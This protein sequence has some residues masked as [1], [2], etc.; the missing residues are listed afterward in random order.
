MQYGKKH[1][2]VAPVTDDEWGKL[3]IEAPTSSLPDAPFLAGHGGNPSAPSSTLVPSHHSSKLGI[4]SGAPAVP[5]RLPTLVMNR[6]PDDPRNA[7]GSMLPGGASLSTTEYGM[8]PPGVMPETT[9]DGRETRRQS[10]QAELAAA[11]ASR[12]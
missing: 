2:I 8:A 1:A 4:T 11:E 3:N 10:L 9:D 12:V 7:R 6:E 5:K